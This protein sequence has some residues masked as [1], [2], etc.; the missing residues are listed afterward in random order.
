[1]GKSFKFSANANKFD[2]EQCEAG[3]RAPLPNVERV[4]CRNNGTDYAN[5][6]TAY[7]V[8]F[9]AWPLRP[10]ENNIYSHDGKPRISDFHCDASNVTNTANSPVQ[11]IVRGRQYKLLGG[12]SRI[13]IL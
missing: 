1:M 5:G 6:G 13:R 9:T 2:S 8:E 4:K 3:F 7:F 11:C 12:E 10:Y